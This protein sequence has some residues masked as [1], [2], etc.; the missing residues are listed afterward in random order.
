M[1]HLPHE[2][3]QNS[4][5]Y[6]SATEAA[7]HFDYAADV[8]LRYLAARFVTDTWEA[9]A[10]SPSGAAHRARL[11]AA[12]AGVLGNRQARQALVFQHIHKVDQLF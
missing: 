7:R 4:P 8:Q 12:A 1:A 3:S 2:F 5:G 11:R 10:P 9:A 6:V